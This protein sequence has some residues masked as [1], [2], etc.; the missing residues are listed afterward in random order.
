MEDPQH[1]NETG[2][3]S[4]KEEPADFTKELCTLINKHG[5]DSRLGIQDFVLAGHIMQTIGLIDQINKNKL[6]F[7]NLL[8]QTK[9]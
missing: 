3:Q 6:Y 4:S 1:N 9:I 7:A 8:K 5:I 2:A